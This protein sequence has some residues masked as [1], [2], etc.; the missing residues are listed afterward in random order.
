MPKFS[1]HFH[2][3]LSQPELDFIDINTDMDMRLYID[4]Y[5]ISIR[6]DDWSKRCNEYIFSFFETAI[7][8]IRNN[9]HLRAKAILNGLSEPN[10]TCLGESRNLPN[11]R[12]VSGKQAVDLYES[13]AKS[14]A[15]KTGL[16]SELAECDL[17]IPGIGRDKISD[18]TTNI[19]RR[20]LIEYT[21]EQCK[22]HNIQIRGQIPSGR[23]WNIEEK[24]WENEYASLPYINDRKILLVPK[25]IVRR[26]LSIDSQ[27]YYNHYVL[28][29]LIEEHLNASTGLVHIFQNGKRTVHKKDLKKIH[30]FDKDWLAKFSQDNPDVLSRYKEAVRN[31]N[32]PRRTL[33]DASFDETFDERA[34]AR[35]LIAGF[36]DIQ[37]GHE[38]AS[39]YHTFMVAVLE[40]IFWPNLIYPRKEFEVDEGRK[41]IDIWYTNAARSGFFYRTHTAHNISSNV[42]IVE[43]KNYAKDP[44]N[45]E[46]D[47]LIGR[48]NAN[49]GKLG[50]LL[51]R[52]A[53]NYDRLLARCKDHARADRGF[54]IPLSDRDMIAMLELIAEERRDDIDAYL[55]NIFIQML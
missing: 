47:Q 21:Q 22:L 6:N 13:L 10:E 11:G 42:I 19:I 44:E 40:F 55:N 15:A 36:V 2:L 31:S 51:Y 41:R 39:R 48:L 46:L 34:F 43:C 14:Q 28:N 20:L 52:S 49:R 50:I 12:G 27:E 3:N 53:S 24:K 37:P 32:N 8:F 45:P 30:P 54:I 5:A 29:F 1:E 4:P 17:F 25:S 26:R 38:H 23:L 7:E 33:L 9:D 35:S 18:I 16:L